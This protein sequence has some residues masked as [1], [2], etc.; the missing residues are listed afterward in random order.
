[1]LKAGQDAAFDI[2]SLDQRKVTKEALE[3]IETP[4]GKIFLGFALID[5]VLDFWLIKAFPLAVRENVASKMPFDLGHKVELLQKCF[6]RV[7]ALSAHRDE[8][9]G[10]LDHIATMNRVR[11]VIAHC[12]LSH[13]IDE[14]EPAILFARL[15][16]NKDRG[17]HGLNDEI[18]TFAT[19]RQL[20]SDAYRVL[21]DMHGM[22][23]KLHA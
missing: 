11:N 3:A 5:Q 4:I 2:P 18:V 19:I 10:I 17:I 8:A 23:A 13:Y 12:A 14:P 7:P 6:Q 1:V 15:K 22:A 9:K 21:A 20:A 16:Y